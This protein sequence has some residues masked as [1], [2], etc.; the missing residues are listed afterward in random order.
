MLLSNYSKVLMLITQIFMKENK[1]LN[2]EY[3]VPLAI[4]IGKIFILF[5]MNFDEVALYWL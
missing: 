4:K 5:W 1:L 3:K 2:K